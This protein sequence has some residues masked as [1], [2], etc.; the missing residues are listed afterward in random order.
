MPNLHTALIGFC[1]LDV[2]VGKEDE[3]R[4]G[5]REEGEG[6]RE[7][8][9]DTLYCSPQFLFYHFGALR[10]GFGNLRSASLN[11]ATVST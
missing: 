8:G 1:S 4:G 5:K 7:E 2:I 10:R 11:E 9:E 3:E 6:R